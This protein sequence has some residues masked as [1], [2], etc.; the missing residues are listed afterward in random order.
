MDA[1]VEL[2][3]FSLNSG[4]SCSGG[5]AVEDDLVPDFI[6]S[7]ASGSGDGDSDGFLNNRSVVLE[8]RGGRCIVLGDEKDMVVGG[9][10]NGCNK[11]LLNCCVE[12][13]ADVEDVGIIWEGGAISF[14]DNGTVAFGE[15]RRGRLFAR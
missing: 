3:N 9:E 12:C 4:E 6:F 1:W 11:W 13:I 10:L 5:D 14:N 8:D 2:F 7:E 15:N